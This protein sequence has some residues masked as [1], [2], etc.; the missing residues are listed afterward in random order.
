[1]KHNDVETSIPLKRLIPYT[2]DGRWP[3]ACQLK[4]NSMTHLTFIVNREWANVSMNLE[5]ISPL[6]QDEANSNSISNE[7]A[8]K[9]DSK[10]VEKPA[11]TSKM[12]MG[13][14]TIIYAITGGIQVLLH[15]GQETRDLV[16]GQTLVCERLDNCS[17]IDIAMTPLPLDSNTK[18]LSDSIVL[19]IQVNTITPEPK[20][21]TSPVLKPM[22]IT[23]P[24]RDRTSSIVIYDDKTFPRA[25][26]D[27]FLETQI[28]LMD[29]GLDAL[30]IST[31]GANA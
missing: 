15:N 27:H 17:P 22:T 11:P 30:N 16:E 19:I 10:D 21:V 18:N 6:E 14:F 26:T 12:L 4:E 20:E 28:S 8:V 25:T 31:H 1:M 23:R 13:N 3:T 24:R 9:K 29:L 2:Y 7:T 5:T